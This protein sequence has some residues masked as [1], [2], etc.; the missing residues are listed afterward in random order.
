MICRGEKTVPCSE[1]FIQPESFCRRRPALGAL[2]FHLEQGSFAF[3][4][5]AISAHFAIFP[6][7]AL[8]RNGNRDPVGG[9][10][11]S[12]CPSCVWLTDRLRYPSI[13]LRGSKR[14]RLQMCPHP[15]LEGRCLN[16]EGQRAIKLVPGDLPQYSFCP[17][18]HGFIIPLADREREFTL[19]AFNQLLV[20]LL[21]L[22]RAD[23]LLCC[24]HQ[25]AS[26]GRIRTGVTN[27]RRNRS[28]T[29]LVRCHAQL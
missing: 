28:S 10:R 5:P 9:T 27:T 25:H 6:N 16:I 26:Q 11:A 14:Q 22:N 23:A 7:H 29:V 18:A 3:D 12:D 2:L 19:Q 17:R 20:A 24:R 1:E 15:L 13:R 21:K 4:A 8:A